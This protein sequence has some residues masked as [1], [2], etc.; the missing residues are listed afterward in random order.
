MN[1]PESTKTTDISLW[2][3]VLNIVGYYLRNRW[4]VLLVGSVAIILGAILNWSWL[5]AAGIAPTLLVLAPC[6]VMC[7]LGL[8]AMKVSGGSK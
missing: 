4:I 2:R 3:A 7:A 8:C 6:A 1:A 5:V